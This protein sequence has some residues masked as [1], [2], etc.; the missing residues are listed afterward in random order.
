MGA[1]TGLAVVWAA[2]TMAAFMVLRWL[3]RM[4]RIGQQPRPWYIGAGC[5]VLLPQ[6]CLAVTG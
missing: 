6:T 3:A 4:P 1:N 2:D 5:V